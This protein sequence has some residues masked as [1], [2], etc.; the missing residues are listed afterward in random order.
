M[1]LVFRVFG[2]A[3]PQGS[4]RAFM[5][6]GARFPVVTSD[7]PHVKSWRHLVAAEAS[8]ALKGRGVLIEGSVG[9]SASFFLPRP[10]A[11]G[12]KTRPH[13]TRPDVDKL[14]RSCL[15][16]LTGVVFRDDSQVV[17][18]SVSKHYAGVGESP[19]A[20]IVITDISEGVNDAQ[21]SQRA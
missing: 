11:L 7:N 10:K 6:K 19:R 18:L 9:V 15:D 20:E 13:L 14:A 16:A 5:P 4:A 3:Q 2:I 12:T 1:S 17:Q 21:V 8:R